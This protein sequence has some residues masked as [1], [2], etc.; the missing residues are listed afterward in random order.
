[1]PI[2]VLETNLPTS[3]ITKEFPVKLAT[4]VSETL[5]KPLKAS[6][7]F[8]EKMH[9]FLQFLDMACHDS[10]GMTPQKNVTRLTLCF[11]H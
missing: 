6:S 4:V 2:V 7:V 1:M 11:S 8:E 5:S 9:M 3:R 10:V